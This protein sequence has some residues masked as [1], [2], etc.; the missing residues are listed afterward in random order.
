MNQST[1]KNILKS[2]MSMLA[3]T[4]LLA[5]AA[6][7]PEGVD[8][9]NPNARPQASDIN[10]S[11][12]VDQETNEVTFT[13]NNQGCNPVWR[14]YKNASPTITTVNGYSEIFAVAGTYTVEVQ[15]SNRNGVCD[16]VKT[17]EFTVNNTIVDWSPYMRR[18]TGNADKQWQIASGTVGHLG[19]GESGSDGLNWWSAQPNDKAGTGLYDNLFTFSD[20]G[21]S[22]TGAYTF[23]PGTAGTVYVNTGC[24]FSPLGQYNTNDGNDYTVPVSVQNT[25]FE[26]GVEGNDLYIQFPSG[27]LLG[28]VPNE[29][30]YNNPKFK[31]QSLKENSL[32]LVIDNGSIA[33]HYIYQPLAKEATPAEM[34]AGT[35][36]DGKIWYWDN[37]NAGHLGCGESGGDGL[38]WWTAAPNEKDG[39]ALYTQSFTFKPDGGYVFN[40]GDCGLYVNVGCS[41]FADENTAGEDFRHAMSA[42]TSS[43]QLVDEGADTYLVFPEGTFLG[44]LPNDA[45]Y[46]SPRFRVISITDNLIDLVVDNGEIAWHYRLAAAGTGGDTPDEFTEG[47]ELMPSEYAQGL[48]GSWTWESSTYGHFGCGESADNATNWWAA[49]ADDKA[50]YGLYDDVLTFKADGTYIFNPGPDGLVYVNIGV[51]CSPFIDAKPDGADAD[52]DVPYAEQTTTYTLSDG[53]ITFPANTVVSYVPSDDFYAAPQVKIVKLTENVL[54]F[55]TTST[56]GISWHYR[57]KRV[58]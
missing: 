55:N 18:L 27:T 42:Q 34:L 31:V 58:N 48:V 26:F 56:V 44:Y 39:V 40:P 52:Y 41:Y 11:V 2:A 19:C 36:A 57:L 50:A 14:I 15:M 47:E 45:A 7:S 9:L 16:G 53:V 12:V 51:T 29:E 32:E 33:W 4:L 37:N 5:V 54:E 43:W 23:D 38:N 1:M 6:C 17:Y 49:P 22:N 46:T 21:G 8:D 25:T 24:S 10:A 3:A 35:S 20:N 28:Y 13:L 30:A